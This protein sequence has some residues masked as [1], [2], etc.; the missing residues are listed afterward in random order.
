M[1]GRKKTPHC[2]VFLA[3][4]NYFLGASAGAAAAGAA[5]SAGLAS[6]AGAAGAAG[7]SAA[8]AAAAGAGAGAAAS[9]FLPQAAKAAAAITAAKTIDLFMIIFLKVSDKTISGKLSSGLVK[10]LLTEQQALELLW[11]S[12]KL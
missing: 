11:F 7:A 10:T 1:K 2:G 8:G 9:S 4:K 12:L 5:A 6:A 3:A